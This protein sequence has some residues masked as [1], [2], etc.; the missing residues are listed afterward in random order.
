MISCI[1]LQ[2][3]EYTSINVKNLDETNMYKKCS[4]KNDNNFKKLKEI[5]S[6]DGTIELWGK[7]KGLS[8]SKNKSDI[9]YNLELDIYGK[10]ILVLKKNETYISLTKNNLLNVLNLEEDNETKTNVD[11][12][13]D[14]ENVEN[15]IEVELT[16][17][18]YEYSDDEYNNDE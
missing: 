11:N 8:N 2:N 6:N 5:E 1:L 7:D 3:N 15:N 13:N 4:L 14:I 16:Y 9:L 17:D 18:A 12:K 10:C